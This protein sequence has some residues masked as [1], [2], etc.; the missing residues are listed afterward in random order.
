MC[1]KPP[2]LFRPFVKH[3]SCPGELVGVGRVLH[4]HVADVGG[5]HRRDVPTDGLF[6]HIVCQAGAACTG[7]W[8]RP[9]REQKRLDLGIAEHETL[10]SELPSFYFASYK[11]CTSPLRFLYNPKT[12]P[13]NP[14]HPLQKT[15]E[16]QTKI[17]C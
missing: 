9:S 4:P 12:K 1:S 16:P 5:P 2:Y 7:G 10:P 6:G 8:R 14:P 3:F 17:E 15:Y 13:H 11:I